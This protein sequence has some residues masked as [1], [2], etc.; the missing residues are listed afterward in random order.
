MIGICVCVYG[1]CNCIIF[2]SMTAGKE[3]ELQGDGLS[4]GGDIVIVSLFVLKKW[5]IL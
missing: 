1:T 2:Q 4:T 3:Y 5:K